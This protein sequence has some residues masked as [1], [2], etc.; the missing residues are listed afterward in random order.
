MHWVWTIFALVSAWLL[1]CICAE[2]PSPSSSGGNSELLE[3]VSKSAPFNLEYG[4][5]HGAKLNNEWV[6]LGTLANAAGVF[7][8]EDVFLP[9]SVNVFAIGFDGTG[10]LGVKIPWNLIHD[11]FSHNEHLVP[12]RTVPMMGVPQAPD[13][14]S[15]GR[16]EAD[17]ASARV[18]GHNV[19]HAARVHHRYSFQIIETHP[20]V[21]RVLERHMHIHFRHIG[22]SASNTDNDAKLQMDAN[23]AII[24]LDDLSVSLGLNDNAYSIFIVNPKASWM[25]DLEAEPHAHHFQRTVRYG[26]RAGF[27]NAEIDQVLAATE[28]ASEPVKEDPYDLSSDHDD[29][30]EHG[31]SPRMSAELI[32]ELEHDAKQEHAHEQSSRQEPQHVKLYEESAAWAKAQLALPFKAG[33]LSAASFAELLKKVPW[34]Q[35][36]TAWLQ[37]NMYAQEDCLVDTWVGPHRSM[38]IDLTAGPLAWG[39]EV[40]GEGVRTHATVPHVDIFASIHASPAYTARHGEGEVAADEDKHV[41]AAFD[42]EKLDAEK[43]VYVAYLRERCS[44]DWHSLIGVCKE[45]YDKLH[46]LEA[47]EAD[48]RTKSGGKS[49]GSEPVPLNHRNSFSFFSDGLETGH[50]FN[51]EADHFLAQ[52]GTLVAQAMQHVITPP[53]GDFFATYAERVLFHVYVLSNHQTYAPLENN[54]PGLLRSTMDQLKLG[55]QEFGYATHS[56]T[57]KDD[58]AL[59]MAFANALKSAVVP[60]LHLGGHFAAVKRLYLDSRVLAAELGSLHMREHIKHADPVEM[61]AVGDLLKRHRVESTS[62]PKAR[63]ARR[64]KTS[65]RA[66]TR[67]R[68]IPIFIFSLDYPLPVFVDKFYQSKAVDGM[69]IAVQSNQH[70]WE[71]HITCNNKAVYWN[72]RDPTRSVLSS[73]ASVLGGLVPPHLAFSAAHNRTVQNW[74][75][76]VGSNPMSPLSHGLWF[77]QMHADAVHRN[78]IVQGIREA[79]SIANAAV[80]RLQRQSTSVANSVLEQARFLARPRKQRR[81]QDEEDVESLLPSLRVIKLTHQRVRTVLAEIWGDVETLDFAEACGRLG[82]LLRVARRMSALTDKFIRDAQAVECQALPQDSGPGAFAY[83]V[84]AAICLTSLLLR[85]SV[86]LRAGTFKPKIN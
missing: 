86:G 13:A 39:P 46:E 82:L 50:R 56:L 84:A 25:F 76:A 63:K 3:E 33:P 32:A 12:H 9:V 4:S 45:M 31:A 41:E 40:G 2:N 74:L 7:Q 73:V 16:A 18:H 21:L 42:W 69:V 83:L 78:Y 81:A 24:I 37:K 61:P 66:H 1:Q 43:A 23:I 27:S 11:W 44:D 55:S 54:L 71:S 53:S 79:T 85:L 34:G 64:Q 57:M 48:H 36:Y 17:A 75:W 72:L 28:R 51:M 80:I 29:S 77:S 15:G 14:H 38:F 22:A 26:Y 8:F 58:P 60:T 30:K 68:E 59:S 35:R 47:F 20:D 10:N 70:L 65:H 19:S 6:S 5:S 52:A 49:G 67:V 62:P